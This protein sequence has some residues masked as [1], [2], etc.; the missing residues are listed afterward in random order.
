M[1][2]ICDR[3]AL[4]EAVGSLSSV[5][6]TRT[7]KDVLRCI[8]MTAADGEMSLVCTD[9]ELALHCTIGSIE[10]EEPCDAVIYADKLLAILRDSVDQTVTIE[11]DGND[12][13][14][15]GADSHFK[16]M[17]YPVADFPKMPD[18]P[19]EDD[20]AL[21][22]SAGDLQDL[23]AKT[24]FATARETS[25]YAI[26]GVL[27]VRDAKRIELV[28]TDGRRL[29]LAK[30][31]CRPGKAAGDGE[32]RSIVPTKALNILLKLLHDGDTTVKIAVTETQ[33]MFDIIQE[34]GTR[35]LLITQMVEGTFPPYEDVIPK[36]Q[37]KKATFASDVLA[38]AVRRASVLS[39][40]DSMGVKLTFS[41]DTLT[42]MSRTPE[43]GEAEIKLPLESYEGEEIEIA[44]NPNFVIDAL[45][46][47]QPEPVQIEMKSSTKPA[48]FR[49][50]SDFLCV[51][52]PV[53]MK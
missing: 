28:A 45:K 52:M 34:D 27:M 22:I 53:N 37:D 8:K 14:I 35:A 49:S 16:V 10:A 24:V 32:K 7:P 25:R 44:F 17:G 38:S 11:T 41:D 36:D 40:Q 13:H 51:I 12:S 31:T 5:A 18:F 15:R 39:T 48:V 19:G 29:A 23:V 1:K 42:V 4:L 9:L 46:V 26:N 50:G 20:Y 2:V 3:S 21:E 47:V 43:L 33:V 30:G 6:P